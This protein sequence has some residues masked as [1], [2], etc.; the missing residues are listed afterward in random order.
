M[1]LLAPEVLYRPATKSDKVTHP[2]IALLAPEVLYRPATKS[3]KVTPNPFCWMPHFCPVIPMFQAWSQS[4]SAH[5]PSTHTHSLSLPGFPSSVFIQSYLE[6]APR[7]G[8]QGIS[9]CVCVCVC[10]C[11]CLCVCVHVSVSVCVCVCVCLCAC[12]CV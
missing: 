12:I 7:E 5:P 3:D 9:V 1:A 8:E 4:R 11:L 2:P 6:L 10:M